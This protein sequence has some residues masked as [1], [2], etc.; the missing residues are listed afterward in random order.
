MSYYVY[1][2]WA[3]ERARVHRGECGFCNHGRGSQTSSSER[4]GR[5]HGPYFDQ[6]IAVTHASQLK[7]RD[8]KVCSYCD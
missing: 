1:E 5:W 6:S 4:N 8:T 3:R 7:R 2:N